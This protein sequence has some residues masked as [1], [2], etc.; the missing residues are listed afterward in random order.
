M[1]DPSCIKKQTPTVFIRNVLTN[2]QS[3]IKHVIFRSL[4]IKTI[5]KI[6]LLLF[7]L[8]LVCKVAVVLSI[9]NKID[10]TGLSI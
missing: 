4:N 3:Q 2:H 9:R 6:Q 1:A 10:V 5:T 8:K 7:R